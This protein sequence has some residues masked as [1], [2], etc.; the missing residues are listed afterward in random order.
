MFHRYLF[1]DDIGK[2]ESTITL[3]TNL[4]TKYS[5]ISLTQSQIATISSELSKIVTVKV[6]VQ[7]RITY[8]LGVLTSLA[9]VDVSINDIEVVATIPDIVDC[10]TTTA[11]A[12]T[13][14]TGTTGN[15]T[16]TIQGKLSKLLCVCTFLY[17]LHKPSTSSYSKSE[18]KMAA[19]LTL[20]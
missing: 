4:L 10:T 20:L 13:G 3:V 12:T 17:S 15:G 14:T 8:L 7:A 5:C 11:P 2:A 1:T 16:A 19:D 18:N 9:G 6:A